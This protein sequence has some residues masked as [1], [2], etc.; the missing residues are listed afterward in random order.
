MDPRCFLN[1]HSPWLPACL[2]L[3]LSLLQHGVICTATHSPL[4]SKVSM[5]AECTAYTVSPKP[6]YLLSVFHAVPFTLAVPWL[7]L[8]PPPLTSHL[9]PFGQG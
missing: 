2:P 9:P 7:C 8:P 6:V 3:T 4:D 1:L 5:V